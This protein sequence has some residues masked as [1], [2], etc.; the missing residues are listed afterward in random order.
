MATME[1]VK[2]AKQTE[3]NLATIR[4][5]L[6]GLAQCGGHRKLV[7]KGESTNMSNNRMQV[8]ERSRE[9]NTVIQ[10]REMMKERKTQTMVDIMMILDTSH[11][12]D[13]R[14]EFM[15]EEDGLTLTAFVKVM[16]K[17]LTK[18]SVR[19]EQLVAALCELFAQVDVN[20]DAT[21]EWD[22]F[23][24]Y[25]HEQGMAEGALEASSVMRYN[26]KKVWEDRSLPKKVESISYYESTDW[27]GI[28]INNSLDLL[29]YDLFGKRHV[30]SL[31]HKAAVLASTYIDNRVKKLIVAVTCDASITIWDTQSVWEASGF[32]VISNKPD[33]SP[34]M[35]APDN[36]NTL[37]WDAESATLFT[38][39]VNGHILTW[40]ITAMEQKS[41]KMQAQKSAIKVIVDVPSLDGILT[42]YLDGT[43]ILWEKG[44]GKKPKKVYRGHRNGIIAI[45]YT[46]ELKMI[47]SAG[48]SD[49]ILIWNPFV[50]RKLTE[51]HGHR[52]P[53]LGLH[54]VALRTGAYQLLSADKSGTFK[55]WDLRTLE[56][57]QSFS[58]D[59]GL[60]DVKQY[61]N[62]PSKNLIIAAGARKFQEFE[63]CFSHTPELTDDEEIVCALYNEVIDSFITAAGC[64]VR[65]WDSSTGQLLKSFPDISPYPIISMCLDDRQRKFFIG[66]AQGNITCHNYINGVLMKSFEAHGDE[67]SQLVYCNLD[68]CLLSSSWD[69]HVCIHDDMDNDEGVLL[70]TMKGHSK[71]ITCLANSFSLKLVATSGADGHI[72]VWHY[73]LGVLEGICKGHSQDVTVLTFLEPFPLLLSADILGNV[74]LWG[75][76]PAHVSLR[77]K[78]ISRIKN[79]LLQSVY[80][81]VLCAAF[82]PEEKCVVTGDEGGEIKV[83]SLDVFL[84]NLKNF[85]R[86]DESMEL[87]PVPEPQ[88]TDILELRLRRRGTTSIPIPPPPNPRESFN[89]SQRGTG[90][91]LADGDKVFP[92]LQQWHAHDCVRSISALQGKREI[93]SIGFDHLVR[94]WSLDGRLLGTLRQGNTIFEEWLFKPGDEEKLAALKEEAATVME[95]IKASGDDK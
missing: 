35:V 95:E 59:A 83:R 61:I 94:V 26:P 27:I 12:S 77:F 9:R 48:V 23:Y 90:A 24:E 20:G 87:Q 5:Y 79:I 29:I 73:G 75:M 41:V 84:Q 55:V 53:M 81:V 39:S 42:G 43:M 14:Q 91:K 13:I 19:E 68:K 86:P 15:D 33:G 65:I 18:N 51:L 60:Q 38:G 28:T 16:L 85:S 36:Q 88:A 10:R 2:F 37:F 31:A 63:F 1:E 69:R 4:S 58:C 89:D 76:P 71:D 54:I 8:Q 72:L 52:A 66:D 62:L 74:C 47:V 82:F 32:A 67:V 78:C 3:N 45:A 40:D 6:S 56:C 64:S 17:Y 34:M 7:V 49:E 80:S 46:H 30:H 92:V 57:L 22:E 93:I 11:L 70:R 50:E 44:G 25:I 21:M